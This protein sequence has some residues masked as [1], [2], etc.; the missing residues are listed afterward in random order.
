MKFEPVK[1]SLQLRY[2]LLCIEIALSEF[3][4][5]RFELIEILKLDLEK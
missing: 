1:V 4:D 3:D 2:E 5:A